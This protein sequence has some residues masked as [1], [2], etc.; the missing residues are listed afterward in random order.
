DVLISLGTDGQMP[1]H[2]PVGIAECLGSAAL[3]PGFC[4]GCPS[5][6]ACGQVLDLGSRLSRRWT[7]EVAELNAFIDAL[8]QSPLL[9]QLGPDLSVIDSIQCVFLLEQGAM[10]SGFLVQRD[11]RTSEQGSHG[12]HADI[13]KQTA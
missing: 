3:Y 11:V 12:E 7:C 13:L 6:H 1:A 9:K 2:R 10:L 8:G 5:R 4:D